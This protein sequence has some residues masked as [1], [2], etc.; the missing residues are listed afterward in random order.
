MNRVA[1]N[2]VM[3]NVAPQ[4]YYDCCLFMD[5]VSMTTVFMATV[6][7]ATVF[8]TPVLMSIVVITN[9]VAPF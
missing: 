4:Y 6:F 1:N 9:T 2:Y 5:T 3:T 7:M 8:M